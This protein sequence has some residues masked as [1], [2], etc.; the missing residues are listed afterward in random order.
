MLRELSDALSEKDLTFSWDDAVLDHLVRH[1]FSATYGARNLRRY[2]QK[3]L[4][5]PIATQ[6]IESYMN[7]VRHLNATVDE[8]KIS[9]LSW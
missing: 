9:L 5:D 6:I 1:S 7:P 2:I 4:E 3:H 8:D